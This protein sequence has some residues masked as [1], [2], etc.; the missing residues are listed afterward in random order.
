MS[1]TTVETEVVRERG[2]KESADGYVR[3]VV[4]LLEGDLKAE[5]EKALRV[6]SAPCWDCLAKKVGEALTGGP[7]VPQPEV[8]GEQG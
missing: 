7:P 3:R 2:K 6:G 1:E 5:A 8:E 4:G